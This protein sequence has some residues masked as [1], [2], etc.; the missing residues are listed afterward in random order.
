MFQ[1][2]NRIFIECRS[3]ANIEIK[4]LLDQV[5]ANPYNIYC[6]IFLERKAIMHDQSR[7]RTH[8]LCLGP[9]LNC[10]VGSSLYILNFSAKFN[11][12]YK[13]QK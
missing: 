8:R 11:S 10:F 12:A 6:V 13:C 5:P 2:M 4:L 7:S 1:S 3:T 9:N